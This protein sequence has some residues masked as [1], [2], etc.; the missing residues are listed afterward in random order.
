M[1]NPIKC[2]FC[3]KIISTEFG[4]PG[5][6]PYCDKFIHPDH[7]NLP[8]EMYGKDMNRPYWSKTHKY[9]QGNPIGYC[10]ICK[11]NG[12]KSRLTYTKYIQCEN[13]AGHTWT[14]NPIKGVH[15]FLGNKNPFRT[16]K[17]CCSLL[18]SKY[19]NENLC[20]PCAMKKFVR[21]KKNPYSEYG[22]VHC[23]IC[24]RTIESSGY[25]ET[26]RQAL[27]NHLTISHHDR[28]TWERF[29]VNPLGASLYESFHGVPPKVKRAI[30]FTPPKG[31]LLKVGEV[32]R[33]DYVPGV[34]S[35]FHNTNFYH[36]AGD[37]GYETVK[38]NWIL[39]TDANGKNFYLLKNDSKS[40]FPKFT[41][42]GIIG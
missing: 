31:V 14:G 35:K 28:N 34:N 33:I 3:H 16:C 8:R 23:P 40:S 1:K 6:C 7:Y 26:P 29:N 2:P 4:E 11:E 42:R 17:Q 36:K 10:P 5:G 18:S 19:S 13:Y 27:A 22:Q 32:S 37:K 24:K 38:S 39:A 9:P 12:L 20:L 21:G 41:S 30:N 15:K 25:Y